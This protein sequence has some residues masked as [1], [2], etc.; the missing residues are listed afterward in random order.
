MRKIC[1][2]CSPNEKVILKNKKRYCRNNNILI[3]SS[4]AKKKTADSKVLYFVDNQLFKLNPFLK[5]IIS[6]SFLNLIYYHKQFNIYYPS[7]NS[8]QTD[9][10]IDFYFAQHYP[11][12]EWTE[13]QKSNHMDAL[14]LVGDFIGCKIKE[15]FTLNKA[16][17]IAI[18]LDAFLDW[19]YH[20]TSPYELDVFSPLNEKMYLFYNGLYEEDATD[21]GSY[22][23][24]TYMAS[25]LKNLGLALP[26]TDENQSTIMPSSTNNSDKVTKGLFEMNTVLNT[27]L[28][29][30]LDELPYVNS[31]VGI[32]WEATSYPRTLMALDIAALRFVYNVQRIPYRYLRHNDLRCRAGVVQTVVSD[33]R[34]L[35]LDLQP[36][37]EMEK[38]FILNLD[39]YNCNPIVDGVIANAAMS[40]SSDVALG[41]SV[42]ERFSFVK[43]VRLGYEETT[44]YLSKFLKDVKLKIASG[45]VEKVNLLVNGKREEYTYEEGDDDIKI[46]KK[47]NGKECVLELNGFEEIEV[48]LE[49]CDNNMQIVIDDVTDD[50]VVNDDVRDDDVRDEEE[51]GDD[52]VRDEEEDGEDVGEEEEG[53]RGRNEILDNLRDEHFSEIL[54]AFK[55]SGKM[56]N[57]SGRALIDA[58]NDFAIEYLT[59]KFRSKIEGHKVPRLGEILEKNELKKR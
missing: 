7:T 30:K 33:G 14:Q 32:D 3:Q 57:L 42:I 25:F 18:N 50:D 52:D 48:N 59:D 51:D 19:S 54:G 49:F 28:S 2:N 8:K 44:V 22:W 15:V 31:G 39:Q 26:Y 40:R 58:V 20:A 45:R 23:F 6:F 47:E 21:K 1:R 55:K 9:N 43:E 29:S 17:I 41:L 36:E 35:I 34:G 27:I 46:V 37:T 53:S 38:N 24:M 56:N 11:I 12:Q 5:S 4:I 13:Q 16:D 10:I